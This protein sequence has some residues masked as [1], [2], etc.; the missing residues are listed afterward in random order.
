MHEL[1]ET[2]NS[3]LVRLSDHSDRQAWAE[4]AEIYEPALYRLARGRGLQ[5]ADALDLVQDVL[6]AVAE[7][8][9]GWAPDPDRGRFRTWLFRVARNLSVN[10]LVRGG[11]LRGSGD[12][13]IH[14]VLNELPAEARREATLFDIEFRREA[15]LHAAGLVRDE[16]AQPVWQAFWLTAVEGVGVEEAARRLETSAGAVYAARSRVLARLRKKVEKYEGR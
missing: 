12:S 13:D 8:I 10:A 14:R 3:L 7:A 1:P 2:R 16:V 4:F 15:F 9:D 6:C 11:R 5:H